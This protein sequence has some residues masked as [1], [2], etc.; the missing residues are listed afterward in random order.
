MLGKILAAIIG[1]GVV[2]TLGSALVGFGLGLGEQET[3]IA[4]ISFFVFYAYSFL[5]S[6]RSASS[7]KAWKWMMIHASILCFLLPISSML[8][9]GIFIA[10]QTSGAAEMA[11]G[12]LGGAIM[13]SIIGFFGFFLGIVFLV[14]GLLIGNKNKPA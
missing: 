13:T 11:G 5:I 6:L 4:F 2:S 7:S 10:D 3:A 14:I 1:G 8:F 12:L 9:T